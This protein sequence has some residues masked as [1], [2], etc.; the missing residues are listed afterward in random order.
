MCGGVVSGGGEADFT[1]SGAREPEPQRR[2]VKMTTPTSI[3]T[4]SIHVLNTMQTMRFVPWLVPTFLD[5]CWPLI[6]DSGR[7]F[8]VSAAS[9]PPNAPYGSK[10]QKRKL[11]LDERASNPCR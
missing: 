2:Q 1:D 11:L 4:K 6:A 7:P 3:Q 9:M 5:R 10:S 8:Q